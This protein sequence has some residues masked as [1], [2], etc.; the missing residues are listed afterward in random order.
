[1]FE[2]NDKGIF[3]KGSRY[4]RLVCRGIYEATFAERVDTFIKQAENRIAH[5]V[6]LPPHRKHSQGNTVA[7]QPYYQPPSDYL[8][9]DSIFVLDPETNEWEPLLDK[10]PEWIRVSYPASAK[11]GRPRFHAKQD[12]VTLLLGPTPGL[13]YQLEMD[14]FAYP[15]SI[16]TTETSYIGNRCESL[17]LYGALVEAYT[18]MKGEM[19]LLNF[20]DNKFKEAAQLFKGFGDGRA[21][22][23]SHEEPDKRVPV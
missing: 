6:R 16:V 8:S 7:N 18:F 5:L 12:D 22:K 19:D 21:R 1:L 15:P 14:Y 11:R 17:L 20:Y 9:A 4:N 2:F 23:D 10:E 13:V 3:K